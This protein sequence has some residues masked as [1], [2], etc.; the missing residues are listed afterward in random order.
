MMELLIGFIIAMVGY[1]FIFGIRESLKEKKEL[2]SE[3][4]ASQ[5]GIPSEAAYITQGPSPEN[6]DPAQ[7]SDISP[8]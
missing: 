6:I 4:N 7:D 3:G 8:A 5:S 2:M 1:M